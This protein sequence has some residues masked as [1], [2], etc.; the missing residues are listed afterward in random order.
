MIIVAAAAMIF[1]FVA[2]AIGWH[3]KERVFFNERSHLVVE[4][5]R[6]PLGSWFS[7]DSI[8]FSIDRI[9]FYENGI[10]GDYVKEIEYRNIDSISL[11]E[12]MFWRKLDIKMPGAV[13]SGHYRIY[14]TKPE[15][16]EEIRRS[17][18]AHIFDGFTYEEKRSFLKKNL[19]SF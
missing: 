2:P 17:V 5:A 8:E 6:Y 4:E 14:F 16:A 19:D 15:T 7:P 11:V 12:G 1:W 18:R 9:I 3:W 10:M 13:F